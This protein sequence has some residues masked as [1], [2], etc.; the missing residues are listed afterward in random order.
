MRQADFPNQNNRICEC[1]A[2]FLHIYTYIKID[3]IK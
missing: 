1:Q 3:T 2:D